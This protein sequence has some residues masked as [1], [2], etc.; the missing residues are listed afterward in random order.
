M[1]R[2]NLDSNIERWCEQTIDEKWGG[3][4]AFP[5][6]LRPVV[7]DVYRSFSRGYLNFLRQ[8]KAKPSDWFPE[9]LV[10]DWGLVDDMRHFFSDYQHITKAFLTLNRQLKKLSDI[11]TEKEPKLYQHVVAEIISDAPL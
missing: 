2:S 8:K 7:Y 11:D 1:Q 6:E 4:D 5:E 10:I 3:S 9:E